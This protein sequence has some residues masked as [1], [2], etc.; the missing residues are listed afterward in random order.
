MRR[1]PEMEDIDGFLGSAHILA[2]ALLDVV[3][4]QLLDQVAGGQVTLPHVKV[5]KLVATTGSYVLG[6]IA[7]FLKVSNAAASKTVD[8]LVRRNLLRRSEDQAD[9]RATHLV[10][11]PAGRRLLAAYE[12]ARRRKLAGIFATFPGE[13]LRR[14]AGLLDRISAGIVNHSGGSGD[15]CLK[16][17]IYF[18]ENCRVGQL[19][20]RGCF[21]RAAAVRTGRRAE[22]SK[23]CV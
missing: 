1:N 11:T 20:R 19:A 7:G 15:V 14:A 6:D 3:E 2:S 4:Q 21:Y 12:S 17:G 16:C 5:M 8:R 9:R 10:L 18:R 22:R 23:V 13:E